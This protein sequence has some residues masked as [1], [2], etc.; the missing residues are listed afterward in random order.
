[1]KII[2]RI[3]NFLKRF[4]E[5]SSNLEYSSNNLAHISA[6]LSP[7]IYEQISSGI[8]T[9]PKYSNPL[10]LEPYG[11]KVSSQ[12]DEDGILYEIFRRIGI[13]KHSFVEFGVGN[14]LEN[15]SLYLLKQGWLGLWIEGSAQNIQYIR[16]KFSKTLVAGQLSLIEAFV[17]RDNINSLI[18]SVFSD[19]IDLLSID[20]DGNDYY[21]WEAINVISP[22]VVCIEYNSKFV[23]PIKWAIEY[24]PEH[25]WDGSD[26]QGAS[27]AALVELSVQKGYQLVGC[28]LNGVNAFF[29]RNDIL[30]GKFMVSDNLIDYYQPPRYYLSS[31]P[32]GHP[33]S[34]QLGKYWE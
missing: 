17:T 10:R 11:Y 26:Y 20:I 18:Q 31:A 33:S 30:D 32:I 6:K 28:N 7:Y 4:T 25:I 15:N 3:K 29:V 23:P 2:K 27:L 19:E 1:M 16:D 14:G 13:K 5:I 8:L 34:P 22:R 12:N 21:I 9:D 24:N